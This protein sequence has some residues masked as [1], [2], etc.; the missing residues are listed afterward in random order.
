MMRR[1]VLRGLVLL[2]IV[3]LALLGCQGGQDA[4][5]PG[6]GGP[7]A[8][9]RGGIQLTTSAESLPA[10]GASTSHIQAI[11]RDASNSLV[12]DGTTVTFEIDSGPLDPGGLSAASSTTTG[13]QALV[14][15]TAGTFEGSVRIRASADVSESTISSTVTLTLQ[16][17]LISITADPPAVQAGGDE[18]DITVQV[19]YSGGD[20]HR[21]GPSR[22]PVPREPRVPSATPQRPNDRGSPRRP[23]AVARLHH[24]CRVPDAR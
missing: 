13:G 24:A 10:D 23:S 21:Y 18:S 2:S 16:G 4:K 12:P 6:Q 17:V 5:L 11:V 19:R 1:H 3:S 14:T 9:P 20:P 8:P 7:T 22:E 15:Y